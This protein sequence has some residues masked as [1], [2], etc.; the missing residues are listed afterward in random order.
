M[1]EQ[2]LKHF[3][4]GGK[5]THSGCEVLPNGKNID[6]TITSIEYKENESVNG[7][8][9][10]AWIAKTKE[11]KLPI[12]LNSTNRKRLA[13]LTGTDYLETVKNFVVTLTSEETKD[14]TDIGGAKIQGLRISKIKAKQTKSD[15]AV[16]TKLDVSDG[17]YAQIKDWLAGDGKTLA[18]VVAKYELTEAALSDLKTIKAE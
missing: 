9:Q 15:V 2:I 4:Y 18:M 1:S 6:V 7:K 10:D 17:N 16:K 12:L 8:S 14:P 3:R 5:L 11:L 13:K